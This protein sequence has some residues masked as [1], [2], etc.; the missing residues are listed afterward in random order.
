MDSTTAEVA[1]YFAPF[2]RVY[3]DGLVER[4]IG[5]D[6]VPPAMNSE[7]GVSTKDVVIAPETGA[8]SYAPL[9]GSIYHNYLTSLVLEADII[10]VS[11][12][13]RLAPENPV[14]AAY[15]DS[16]LRFSGWFPHWLGGVKLQGICVVHPY[17]GRKSEDDVGKVDDNASGGRPD[18]RPGVDNRWLYV[19]PTTSGF[20]DP[21]EG[22]AEGKRV[23][24]YE[25]LGKSGWSGE[26][27]I[28]ETE[29][30]GHV[31][32][33]FKPSCERA[34]TLMK[35]IVSFINQE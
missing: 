20:N 9:T 27:E 7:T 17:F 18:V 25:T 33:L 10:A 8:S 34:V 15:E 5:T 13:Y 22:C 23:V 19:C 16:W 35:R 29:G 1:Y 14:P 30:E 31:F 11:V 12:A 24:Y 4:L 32:H 21:R 3:T 6:V 26:V 2:L 28:M